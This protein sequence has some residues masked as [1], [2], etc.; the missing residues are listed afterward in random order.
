MSQCSSTDWKLHI[1]YSHSKLSL[2]RRLPQKEILK[3]IRKIKW[4]FGMV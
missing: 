3:P 1:S 2:Q 4:T